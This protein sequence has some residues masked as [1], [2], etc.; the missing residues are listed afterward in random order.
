MSNGSSSPK[1]SSC[2][3]CEGEPSLNTI[4]NRPGLSALSYRL[5]NYGTFLQRLLDEI[6][7]VRIGDGPNQGAQPLAGLTTRSLDDPSIAL[8]D[9]WAVIADVLTFYQERIANEG[10][11]RTATERRSVLELAREI[12]Y[13]LNPG[14]AASAYLQFTVEEIIGAAAAL[15]PGGRAP[16]APGPGS[17]PFNSG[18]VDIPEGTQVQSVPAPGKLPQPFETAL[19]FQARAEWNSLEPRLSR[20]ADL[21]LSGGKLYLIGATTAFAPGQ[22]VSLPENE[23]Y[24]VNPPAPEPTLLFELLSSGLL[25]SITTLAG[26]V[27]EI[28]LAGNAEPAKVTPLNKFSFA[29]LALTASSS[30]AVAVSS[31][32]AKISKLPP[33]TSG[34]IVFHPGIGILPGIIG[35]LPPLVVG[36]LIPAVEVHEIYL[37]GT[38]TNLKAGDRML[39]VGTS[40]KS[41]LTKTLPLIIRAIEVQS[42]RNVTRVEFAD[43]PQD[44]SF[45]PAT[46]AAEVLQQ[47]KIPF[48]HNTVRTH[49]L[50]TTIS[51][52]DLQAFLKMNQWNAN[53]LMAMVNN[54]PPAPLGA[55][56]AFAFRASGGFFGHN[57]PLWKSLPDPSKSQRADPY[58]LSWD[59]ANNG[60]GT[61]IWTDSQGNLYQDANV[62]LER[63]FPQIQANSWALF[64]TKALP[65]AAYQVHEVV[66]KS[67]SDYSLS[68]KSTGLQLGF[69]ADV[70]PYDYLGGI[71]I[72]NPAVASWGHDRLDVFVIGTDRALYHK[73]WDGNSWGPTTT[74]YEYMGGIVVGDPAV[75]SWDHDR[76]DVFVIGTDGALYHKAWNGAQ[77]QPSVT[78]YDRLGTPKAGVGVRGNPVAVSWDHDRLDIFVVGTDGALYHKWWDGANWGPSVTEFEFMGGIVVGDPTVSSWD[79]DRLDVFVIGTDGAL[80]HKAWNGSQW[81]PSVT[82]YD[83]LGTPDNGVTLT[84][85][86][87]VNSWGHDR[88]DVFAVGTDGALYHKWWDQYYW[89]PSFT[90]YEFMSGGITRDPAVVSWDHDRLD[91]LVIG[92]DDS[93]WH[94]AW[95][96]KQWSPS[97]IGYEY[98]G[99]SIRSKPVAVSWDHDRIDAFVI[100][101]DRALYHKAWDGTSW[102]KLSFPVRKTTAF[103]Q[104]EQLTL[105]DF[106]VVDDIPAGTTEL[107]L[108][109]MVLGLAPGQPVAL[110]GVRADS[111]AVSVNEVVALSDIVH[112]AGFTVLK[113]KVPLQNSYQRQSLVISANV[114]LATHGAT[115]QEVLGNGDGSKS[116]QSFTLKRRPLTYVSAPT[117]SGSAST[118]QVRVNDLAWQE[119]P[120]FYGLASSDEEYVVRLADDGTPTITFGDPAARLKSGQQ[121]V[122]AVYRTGIGMDGNVDA[123]SLTM[124]MSRPPGLRGVSNPLPAS[125]GADPQDLDHARA[126]APLAV[127][128]LDRIISLDDY[129]NFARAFAGV[130]KAQ[131]IAVWSGQTRLVH[132]TIAQAS[133]APLAASAP[134]FQTLTQ[135]IQAAHDPV[136]PF[137]VAGY[138][139]L[140]FN[141]AA[142]ILVDTPRYV[143]QKVIS[144]VAEVLKS[145][146]SFA[147]RS[148]A[149]PVT[150][151]EII[152][153]IQSVPG[154]IAT[155]LSNLYYTTD[156]TGPF[157]SEPPAFLPAAPAHWAGGD[158][159][160]AQL[161]LLNPL[162]VT[163]TEISS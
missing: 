51:E 117:P 36:N 143:G 73:W 68:G 14:V 21:A 59:G 144:Q 145:A 43:N 16:A 8:L 114:T 115:V 60:T 56:G 153:M 110:S 83:R 67:L 151:A 17:S 25:H 128:T 78:G 38:N 26:G 136:Q 158:I 74:G 109:N 133:G 149:Q 41:S 13:E 159:V 42:S 125:G 121:N 27:K 101:S 129:E 31:A 23:V 88:L 104:S 107:M 47:Q 98:L 33:K 95:D 147:S 30:H 15:T 10:Y 94:K 45:A 2:G 154:V 86:P 81:Q 35:V 66:E 112:V 29:P 18:I 19:D 9:A 63:S 12:G 148:F 113:F 64:E 52:S 137:M 1:L 161:L 20:R 156:S 163:L 7:S 77:W 5:G 84:G 150:A 119:S 72:G 111:T 120:S 91:V 92:T 139:P 108:N 75:V 76:L 105:A 157:Q 61:S 93:L 82:G 130:G 11:L 54:P 70:A 160:P 39:L 96:G 6:R 89:G 138:Q 90:G 53:D 3:C 71:C 22:F 134:L 58:P 62:Y 44:P 4:A 34:G 28:A 79:H 124:L 155:N 118:L 65:P 131:A 50:E 46:F 80:Y 102:G 127:L 126:D 140:T 146:F 132:I 97:V 103:V 116:N 87:V 85:S 122:R 40:S 123:N 141:L 37:Q 162:G 135:A 106:P 142:S 69:S 100:G 48:S 55:D 99:G 152:T 49:I 32:A 24:L 57:A